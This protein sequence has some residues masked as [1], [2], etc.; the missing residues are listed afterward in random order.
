MKINDLKLKTFFR[1]QRSEY[2]NKS[3]EIEEL[4]DKPEKWMQKEEKN[5]F[6]LKQ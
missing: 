3:K 1:I 4:T 5:R 2:K 6:E